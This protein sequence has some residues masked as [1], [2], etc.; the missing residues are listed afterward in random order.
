MKVT[1]INTSDAGGGAPAACMRLLKALEQ[2]QVDV[3]MLV[4]EKK[5]SEPRVNSI[6]NWFLGRQAAKFNFLYERLPFIWFRAKTPEVRFAFS[7][8]NTSTDISRQPAVT[9]AD[10]LH[11]HW[12]NFG[13]LSINDLEKLQQSGKPIVWTLHDMWTFT[14]GCHYAGD[15]DHFVKEC[16]N[17]W[18][19]K[20]ANE[21]DLSHS[22][23][24]R[25]LEM[26][27]SAKNIVFVTCSNWLA[28]VAKTSSLLKDFRIE[29][30]PNAI[31]TEIFSPKDQN[32][33][34][35]RWDIDPAKKIILFG[36]ANILDRRK[37]ITYLVEALNVLRE[38]YAGKDDLGIVIFGKNKSFDISQLPFKVYEMNVINSQQAMAELYNLADVYVT[39]AI[40][41]NLPNTV[42][43]ALACGT[44]VVAFNT[45]GIP[46]MVDH[47]QNGYLAEFKSAA[48]FAAGINYVLTSDQKSELSAN[49]RKKVLDNFTNALVAEK[50]IA[51]YK[52]ILK[53]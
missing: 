26:F 42:M 41:D 16:G 28:E 36:A 17:C 2:K 44:P 48:D 14:G 3:H 27:K 33:T 9:N 21:N 31:D 19:L 11:L 49:A 22:G 52:S 25:K 50:Y 51:V 53:K 24:L 32:A 40:E 34:R 5:T 10:I 1:L 39:P 45:G 8:A 46:D 30:I 15:C 38:K 23:W 37:G 18:M 7:P 29:A 35:E 12:T 47:R 20:G 43:E 6:S 4:Q 13:F